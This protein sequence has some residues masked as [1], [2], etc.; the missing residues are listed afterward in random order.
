MPFYHDSSP[1]RGSFSLVRGKIPPACDSPFVRTRRALDET[2]P[3]ERRWAECGRPVHQCFKPWRPTQD[4]ELRVPGWAGTGPGFALGGLVR[5]CLSR[6]HNPRRK[7]YSLV[8]ASVSEIRER[9]FGLLA[10]PIRDRS[11][12]PSSA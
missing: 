4:S 9:Q 1:P 8:L 6:S 10:A 3:S 12:P 2:S 5:P 7:M 11:T